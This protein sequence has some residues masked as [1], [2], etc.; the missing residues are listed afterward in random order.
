M[1]LRW[2]IR[3][4]QQPQKRPSPFHLS[5]QARCFLAQR[6]WTLTPPI[7]RPPRRCPPPNVS[8]FFS[9]AGPSSPNGR[10]L[11]AYGGDPSL[12]RQDGGK[13]QRSIGFFGR[14][15][16]R[17][18]LGNTAASPSSPTAVV[19]GEPAPPIIPVLQ[20][21]QHLLRSLTCARRLLLLRWLAY[22]AG[23]PSTGSLPP[24]R[25][26]P[27]ERAHG[28]RWHR[29]KSVAAGGIKERL[30]FAGVSTRR[31]G[32]A[33]NASNPNLSGAAVHAKPVKGGNAQLTVITLSPLDAYPRLP[34]ADV[35]FW[36]RGAEGAKAVR[37]GMERASD[38]RSPEYAAV[39]GSVGER[40]LSAGEEK[41]KQSRRARQIRLWESQTQSQSKEE[42]EGSGFAGKG[43]RRVMKS[44]ARH[45]AK[46][47]VAYAR[48]EAMRRE[49][50][51][52][53]SQSSSRVY[54][55]GSAAW[56]ASPSAGNGA[57]VKAGSA[58]S[59]FSNVNLS[60]A[61]SLAGA[62][63]HTN[64]LH[65]RPPTVKSKST[66]QPSKS[67]SGNSVV[68]SS[69][70]PT[71]P[72][73]LIDV[74]ALRP[75]RPALAAAA[76]KERDGS[77][78]GGAILASLDTCSAGA[79]D[80]RHRVLKSGSV[81]SLGAPTTTATST[82]STSPSAS[83]GLHPQKRGGRSCEYC[84][85]DIASKAR[86]GE[87]DTARLRPSRLRRRGRGRTGADGGGGGDSYRDSALGRDL[88]DLPGAG[89]IVLLMRS[90]EV[91][92]EGFEPAAMAEEYH[93]VPVPPT[94]ATFADSGQAILGP[95]T[96]RPIPPRA[97]PRMLARQ[98]AATAHGRL[99]IPILQ[100][101]ARQRS[102]TM[103][104]LRQQRTIP[105]AWRSRR[106]R[107]RGRSRS[108]VECGGPWRVGEADRRHTEFLGFMTSRS[109]SYSRFRLRVHILWNTST[110]FFLGINCT[111]EHWGGGSGRHGK[112]ERVRR[113]GCG[114]AVW[115]GDGDGRVGIARQSFPACAEVDAWWGWSA[116]RADW[117]IGTAEFGRIR[118]NWQIIFML[119]KA[120]LRVFLPLHEL[121]NAPA[122]NTRTVV[123]IPTIIAV[124]QPAVR[125]P[126]LLAYASEM[127]GVKCWLFA[128]WLV[129][130]WQHSANSTSNKSGSPRGTSRRWRRR[131]DDRSGLELGARQL[132]ASLR[133]PGA[134]D[135]VGRQRN[136]R[137]RRSVGR[138]QLRD[139]ERLLVAA[140][141]SSS[142]S[143]GGWTWHLADS[144]RPSLLLLPA[145]RPGR[146]SSY[147]DPP[148]VCPWTPEPRERVD[149]T[150]DDYIGFQ[151]GVSRLHSHMP[152]YGGNIGS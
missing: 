34:G 7:P 54:A 78:V 81:V 135:K 132:P 15:R 122:S 73:P 50:R 126:W 10:G 21:P 151:I 8:L 75:S 120:K 149:A 97:R 60:S 65:F 74:A 24:S 37:E 57:G 114:V 14:K 133:V 30:R 101:T 130:E 45:G 23:Y 12:C 5:L 82:A 71:K 6:H 63:S 26:H 137:H 77:P 51:R 142:R 66:R 138:R 1:P 17:N 107:L 16:S 99:H 43:V 58:L 88:A 119:N 110:V 124:P 115:D 125:F 22:V 25:T 49:M 139:C 68:S 106:W 140:A 90:G 94:T 144:S 9:S 52:S 48:R 134:A 11:L 87:G 42:E 67:Q 32:R 29:P 83:P 146:F 121:C 72:Q 85:E 53:R 123:L 35:G 76:A 40:G 18:E 118:Q 143:S 148:P 112:G 36:G 4:Q 70:L 33:A 62:S 27:L 93:L 80:A 20:P 89:G 98:R 19:A 136:A 64:L 2:P 104:P 100:R 152:V 147:A 56:N 69:R 59:S 95:P 128:A 131:P 47:E 92:L 105:G 44:E 55:S 127:V 108:G 141:D 79:K 28:V 61:G 113:G 145:S 111:M 91:S 13:K 39:T 116:E 150:E 3:A 129:R 84:G 31:E 41:K 117:Q 102:N 38:D 96:P 103:M 86:R 46:S 109:L